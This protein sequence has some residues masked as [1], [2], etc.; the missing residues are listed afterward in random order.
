MNQNQ[1]IIL[2]AGPTGSGKSKLAIELAKHLDGEIINADSMQIYKEISCLSSRPNK[3]DQKKII[4]HLYGIRSVQSQ[5]STG[6]WLKL[7]EKKIINCFK[8]KK[9]P[10]LVGGTG[11]YFKTITDGLISIPKIPDNL[12]K[13]A[14]NLQNKIGQKF[15][16]SKLIKIDPLIG[17]RIN[18][19]DVQRCLRAYEIKKYTGIS[20]FR[21][22]KKTKP[23]F[24]DKLFR[25]IFLN[26]PKQILHA[27]IDDRVERMFRQGAVKEVQ[28][29]LKKQI[30]KNLSSRKLIGVEE[31]EM[32]LNNLLSINQ[33]KERIKI[34]TRQYAKRQFTWSRGHMKNWNRIFSENNSILFKKAL[35]LSS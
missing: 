28:K 34:K 30:N 26:I 4:H 25:K 9:I 13:D 27:K 21:W 31:I 29:F 23:S 11:L 14:R 2:L 24:E 22:I 33:T 35:S 1:R 32:F 17:K 12:R 16:F 10:I 15:F 20:V 3:I 5:F 6:D 7:A 8:R 19:N 18:S